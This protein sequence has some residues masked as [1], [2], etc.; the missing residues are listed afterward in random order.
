MSQEFHC[1]CNT[2]LND[3]TVLSTMV[4]Q[5]DFCNIVQRLKNIDN[6]IEANIFWLLSIQKNLSSISSKLGLDITSQHDPQIKSQ[7]LTHTIHR[8]ESFFNHSSFGPIM[9]LMDTVSKRI[10]TEYKLN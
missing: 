5:I 4:E 6:I 10:N 9:S 7:E 3:N 8:L 1:H 2:A